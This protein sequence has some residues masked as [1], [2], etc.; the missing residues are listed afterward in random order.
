MLHNHCNI[1]PFFN[2]LH[3]PAER[4]ICWTVSTKSLIS[5]S[6]DKTFPEVLL[7]CDLTYLK[8]NIYNQQNIVFCRSISYP[9]CRVLVIQFTRDDVIDLERKLCLNIFG[10][11]NLLLSKCMNQLICLAC[12]VYLSM[13]VQR[14]IYALYLPVLCLILCLLFCLVLQCI[15]LNWMF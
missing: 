11:N 12:L 5:E 3:C 14:Y 1:H 4:K 6:S 8:F 15:Y 10:V 9:M 7:S 13:F 2:S